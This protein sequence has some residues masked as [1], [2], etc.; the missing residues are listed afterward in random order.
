MFKIGDTFKCGNDYYMLV[1][2]RKTKPDGNQFVSL[3]CL[4]NGLRMWSDHFAKPRIKVKNV[5]SI[6]PEEL[7]N[8]V[9]YNTFQSLVLVKSVIK[10]IPEDEYG[11]LIK[12]LSNQGYPLGYFDMDYIYGEK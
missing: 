9:G 10:E 1:D 2:A 6:E 8:L 3:V 12:T 5:F 4:G 11:Q 7:V